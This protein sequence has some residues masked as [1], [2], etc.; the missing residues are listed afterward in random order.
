MKNFNWSEK[1]E[2]R[3][4]L[5]KRYEPIQPFIF[6]ELLVRA[7]AG[8]VFDIGANVGYY[9]LLSSL[10]PAVTEIHAFEP[11]LAA[12]SQLR[13]NTV[14]ND[15]SSRITVHESAVSDT[16]GLADF[17]VAGPMSGINSISGTTFHAAD[18]YHQT[19][20]VSI[21]RLDDIIRLSDEKIAA[22]IDVEG[23]E[24]S[25]IRGAQQTFSNRPGILQVES[26]PAGAALVAGAVREIGYHKILSIGNDMY[27]TNIP[28]LLEY[29]QQRNVL[30]SASTHMIQANLGMWRR[31]VVRP[32]LIEMDAAFDGTGITARIS[33]NNR[34]LEDDLEY[35]F[36]LLSGGRRIDTKWYQDNPAV[37]FSYPDNTNENTLQIIGFARGK[38]NPDIKCRRA[39]DVKR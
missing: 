1:S 11:D 14:M 34:L 29:E 30:Q 18:K 27:F 16:T 21:C 31:D 6:Y 33:P 10:A 37:H 15:L 9:S 17:S 23:H 7:E 32:A 25:A 8:V 2:A 35:A 4:A 20:Q 5:T 24:E 22:K 38:G 13:A 12:V 39:A 26:Y 36:Y 28:D 3:N 19:R